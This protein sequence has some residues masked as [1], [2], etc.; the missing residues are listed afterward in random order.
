ML[1][2]GI[3]NTLLKKLSALIW[4]VRIT[5][6]T[7][8]NKHPRLDLLAV[9]LFLVPMI[10]MSGKIA[11][12]DSIKSALIPIL[13]MCLLFFIVCWYILADAK[14][15]KTL[16]EFQSVKTYREEELKNAYAKR[17]SFEKYPLECIGFDKEG[18]SNLETDVKNALSVA[19]LCPTSYSSYAHFKAQTDD[20]I[21]GIKE[22]IDW[23]LSVIAEV[24]AKIDR[25]AKVAKALWELMLIWHCVAVENI[26]PQ[27][28][29][30]DFSSD[31]SF[32]GNYIDVLLRYAITE[33]TESIHTTEENTFERGIENTFKMIDESS[34]FWQKELMMKKTFHDGELT[35]SVHN[36][37][38][39]KVPAWF[40]H[41]P[42]DK[43]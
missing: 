7:F 3:M 1:I 24:E 41:W 25:T 43:I 11:L 27:H 36:P 10:I 31:M 12:A 13:V 22:D 39:E 32:P 23:F 17:E 15:L 34:V 8:K 40:I 20:L 19:S 29:N 5:L 2:G 16:R 9:L 6:W 38:I 14:I 4:K 18:L 28:E 42:Q 37:F 21:A 33:D 35:I 30:S 26:T